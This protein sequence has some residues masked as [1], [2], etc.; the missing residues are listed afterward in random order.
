MQGIGDD[1]ITMHKP[2][3][4][5]SPYFHILALFKSFKPKVASWTKAMK[6]LQSIIL[7]RQT[8]TFH[9]FSK[10]TMCW[11]PQEKRLLIFESHGD[12]NWCT[13][14]RRNLIHMWSWQVVL[15]NLLCSHQQSWAGPLLLRKRA[16]NPHHARLTDLWVST[17]FPSSPIEAVEEKPSI[18]WH[19]AISIY[20]T[21]ITSMWSI[22]SILARRGLTHCSLTDTDGG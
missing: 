2:A 18:C 14:C 13:S 10:L 16:L 9:H 5:V 20:W 21:H 17:Q 3:L 11:W 22:H 1:S 8:I 7:I 6:S 4:R 12:S 15:G 19:P